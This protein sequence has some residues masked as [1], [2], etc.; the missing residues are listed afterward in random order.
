VHVIDAINVGKDA[1]DDVAWNL[2][3]DI[4]LQQPGSVDLWGWIMSQTSRHDI[5]DKG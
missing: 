3:N 2:P 5:D 1:A 4:V